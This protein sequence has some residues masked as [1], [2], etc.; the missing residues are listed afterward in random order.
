MKA[1][2]TNETQTTKEDVNVNEGKSFWSRFCQKHGINS[3]LVMLKVTLFVMHGGNF[4]VM[5]FIK[6]RISHI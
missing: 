1:P 6:K 4:F 2:T 5:D 3:N